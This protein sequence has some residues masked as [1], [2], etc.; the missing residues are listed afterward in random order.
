MQ[1][2][3]YLSIRQNAIEDPWCVAR[4]VTRVVLVKLAVSKV[5]QVHWFLWS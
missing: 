4:L 1:Q 2:P 5:T 3:T